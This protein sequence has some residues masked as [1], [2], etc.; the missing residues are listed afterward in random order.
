M[1]KY[2][3]PSILILLVA[4]CVSLVAFRP[5]NEQ[6]NALEYMTV[7]TVE[8]IIP[9]GLGRSRILI[10][11]SNGKTEDGKIQNLYS[12]GGINMGNIQENDVD[13]TAKLAELSGEG[14]VL[15]STV[16]GV[17]SPSQGVNQ[18]IFL[19]RYLLSR[20]K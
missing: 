19:T 13:V 1:K 6:P 11:H 9:G 5:S 17:Q 3:N 18:G 2:L 16:A 8:S 7:T 10:S 14:W 15:E 20:E 12:I 4:I